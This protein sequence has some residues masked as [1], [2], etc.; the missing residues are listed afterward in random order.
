MRRHSGDDRSL[1][2]SPDTL[3]L[4][5]RLILPHQSRGL[6]QGTGLQGEADIDISYIS[7]VCAAVREILSRQ[8]PSD[9]KKGQHGLVINNQPVKLSAASRKAD[10]LGR[11]SDGVLEYKA[12]RD[13]T[14]YPQLQLFLITAAE[15]GC[16]GR[17]GWRDGA[18]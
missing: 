9:S 4:A 14:G 16:F 3:S 18:N 1:V 17:I 15:E 11:G 8:P 13:S 2:N 7:S 5:S 6:R 10:H 12:F